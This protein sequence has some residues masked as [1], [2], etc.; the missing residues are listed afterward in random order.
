MLLNKMRQITTQNGLGAS[1]FGSRFFMVPSISVVT[2]D[3]TLPL[4]RNRLLPL[5]YFLRG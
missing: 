5:S 2:K 4:H 3:I 1:E